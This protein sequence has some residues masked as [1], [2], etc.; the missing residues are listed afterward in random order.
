MASTKAVMEHLRE[1]GELDGDRYDGVLVCCYSV[2]GLVCELMSATWA[3]GGVAAMGIFEAS[4]LAAISL[5]SPLGAAE[6][7]CWGIVTTGPF[8]EDHLT[9]GVEIFLGSSAHFAGVVSTGLDP[10]EVHSPAGG[11]E[12]I[13]SVVKPVVMKLL[14]RGRVRCVILGCAGMAG[15]EEI[16]R[17]TAR[18][19]YGDEG[20]NIF[21]IDAVKAGIMQLEQLIR[22]RKMFLKQ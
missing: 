21:V 12:S 19:V 15:L 22:S 5:V 2:S 4:V 17:S 9:R 18:E 10:E 11:H 8:W 6:P 16:I 20:N 13:V 7:A 1:T 14:L 3:H